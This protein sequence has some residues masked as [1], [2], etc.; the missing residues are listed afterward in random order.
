[1]NVCV[2]CYL[3]FPEFSNAQI[4]LHGCESKY[5]AKI[6]KQIIESSVV[7]DKL[8]AIKMLTERR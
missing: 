4:T 5:H 1:M 6:L 7:S 3:I 8:E 2:I